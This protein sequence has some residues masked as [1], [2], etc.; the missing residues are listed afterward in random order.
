MWQ[1]LNNVLNPDEARQLLDGTLFEY[2]CPRWGAET[3]SYPARR[4]A[5]TAFHTAAR[6]T[7]SRRLISSPERYTDGSD[8]SRDRISS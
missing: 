8:R 6:L 1:S 5:S 4:R 2:R 3:I 7:P